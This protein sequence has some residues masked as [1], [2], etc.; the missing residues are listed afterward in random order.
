VRAELKRLENLD[1]YEALTCVAGDGKIH[2]TATPIERD[3]A[4]RALYRW[5]GGADRLA[6]GRVAEL[7]AAGV[8]KR[9]DGWFGLVDFESGAAIGAGRGS[10]FWNLFLQRW[11]VLCAAATPGEIWFAR[12][13]TPV[14]PFGYARRVATHGDYNFYNPTQEPLFDQEC[15][16]RICFAG[17]YT[18]SFSAAKSP[19][20]RYDYNQ[21]MYRLTLDDPRLELPIAIYR[22]R[23]AGGPDGG[24]RLW[25][26]DQVEAAKAWERI[27]EVAC[28]ALPSI[29]RGA[30]AIPVFASGDD[31]ERGA[32]TLSLA[33]T[34]VGDAP[35]FVGLPLETSAP[36]EKL[37]P[38][39]RSPAL[40]VL[41]EYR[42]V[43]DRSVCYSTTPTPPPG[44]EAGGR[45]LCRVWRVPTAALVLD[46]KA[47]PIDP[48]G[49]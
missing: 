13:D 14:G 34:T 46:W 6:P 45:P 33:P 23:D 24:I 22:V 8:M 49:R 4:G 25:R 5:K 36:S 3:A 19:T 41:T 42:R 11:V 30:P 32:T 47:T 21:L 1:E 16:R 27:E 35:R 15:G 20:P 40:V 31:G 2:G 39:F 28:F 12:G 18:T 44:C 9:D 37:P 10:V 48:R 26:R 17:T 43:A 38:E 29:S 7:I